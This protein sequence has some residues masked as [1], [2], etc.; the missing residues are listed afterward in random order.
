MEMQKEDRYVVKQMIQR[1]QGRHRQALAFAAETKVSGGAIK[2]F[3]VP[4]VRRDNCSIHFRNEVAAGRSPPTGGGLF[5]LPPFPPSPP[6]APRMVDKQVTRQV[7]DGYYAK[8]Q[9]A[10]SELGFPLTVLA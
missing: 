5:G 8:I 2:V 10:Y 4:C 3:V 9:V 6:P 1:V 7:P